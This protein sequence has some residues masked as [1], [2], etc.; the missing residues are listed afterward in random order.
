MAVP[1][2]INAMKP[3]SSEVQCIKGH[4][5]VYAVKSRYDKATKRS[6]SDRI[7]CIGKIYE[8]VGFVPNKKGQDNSISVTK[9]YG[10]THTVMEL[11]KGLFD[12][13]RKHFP[14][15]FLR[16]YVLAILKL[17]ETDLT[18]KRI[19]WA[20]ERSA[21]SLLLPE[22]HLSKNTVTDF[23]ERLSLQ[24]GSMVSFMREF[25]IAENS[26]V[27]FDG[28]SQ[29]ATSNDNPYVERGYT[30]GKKNTTQ[31]R[32]IYAFETQTRR[33]IY[34]NILPGNITDRTALITSFEE[35]DLKNCTIIL[36][37]GFFSDSNIRFMLDEEVKF[38]IPLKSNT[39]LVDKE[40]KP[41]LAYKTV[42]GNSFKYHNRFIFYR[43][44]PCDKYEGCKVIVYYD[45]G[46]NKE[47]EKERFKKANKKYG[48]DIP[49]EALVKLYKECEMLG[50]T[51]LLVKSNSDAKQIYLDFK[52]RWSIESMFDTMKN[53]LSFTMNYE[54]KYTTQMGWSFIEFICLQMHY[55][56]NE[57]LIRE[58]LYT[59]YDVNDVLSY[60]KSIEQSNCNVD[61][62]WRISN[63]TQKKKELLDSLGIS[64][65]PIT[66]SPEYNIG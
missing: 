56:I 50:V 58:D 23:M 1:E 28:T 14:S 30:P 59:K 61:G 51:M 27:I 38:M 9:E 3:P 33:P 52:T 42:M 57:I 43:E 17:M 39:T 11:T 29:T 63:L 65:Q 26:S 41:F 4:Y 54:V 13:L 48:E 6:Y 35:L 66:Q 7:G 21:V 15:D 64:L 55:E 36:D 10:A 49:Q 53:T 18:S 5:Y 24:R 22:V 32:Q 44:I 31:I 46:R 37:N 8:G 34:Y 40:Y 47:L 62:Q 12:R 19:D 60:L 2:H 25:Q 16:I 20:Y 45:E